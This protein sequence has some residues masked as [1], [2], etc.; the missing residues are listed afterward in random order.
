MAANRLQLGMNPD[1]FLSGLLI[2]S[3]SVL[4]IG[5]NSSLVKCDNNDAFSSATLS[6][7]VGL[8]SLP[9]SCLRTCSSIF[10]ILGL[11][12]FSIIAPLSHKYYNILQLLRY[13]IY[14]KR[15]S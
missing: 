11:S 3:P 12:Q 14:K 15:G 10:Q 13:N 9:T 7:A 4:T 8:L 2:V 1:P 5:V 6:S